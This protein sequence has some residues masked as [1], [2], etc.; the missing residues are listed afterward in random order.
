MGIRRE[1]LGSAPLIRLYYLIGK[2]ETC[3]GSG[4]SCQARRGSGLQTL[5]GGTKR[6]C[7]ENIVSL[8]D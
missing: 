5:L 7:T 4:V 1:G 6:E 8:L 2:E 3:L